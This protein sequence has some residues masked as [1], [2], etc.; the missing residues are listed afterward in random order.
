[1]RERQSFSDSHAAGR[2]CNT[3]LNLLGVPLVKERNM[4]Y[5]GVLL[6]FSVL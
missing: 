1:M 6:D 2:L 3:R 5:L 4:N